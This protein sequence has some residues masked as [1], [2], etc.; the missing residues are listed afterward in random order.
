MKKAYLHTVTVG[1]IVG[2]IGWGCFQLFTQSIIDIFGQESELYNQFALKCFHVFLSVIFLT[3]F[4]IPSG[5][6]FQSIGKPIKAM[7]ATMTRQLIYFLP[8]AFIM[9]HFFGVEGL[10]YAG[11]IGD[12]LA[13]ITVAIL[14]LK[15]MTLL[16]KQI[17]LQEA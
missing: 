3:G 2:I 13:A 5:I 7:A 16:N 6:F 14:I 10:L 17:K 8:V 4:L 12:T 9:A 15:E 11:P 1:L